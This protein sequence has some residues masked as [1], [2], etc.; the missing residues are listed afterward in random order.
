[1]NDGFE[2]GDLEVYPWAAARVSIWR[3]NHELLAAAVEAAGFDEISPLFYFSQDPD[4]PADVA[5]FLFNLQNYW[6]LQKEIYTSCAVRPTLTNRVSPEGDVT[7][8][9]QLLTHF[10]VSETVRAAEEFADG[11]HVW[12]ANPST[13]W[14]DA[15]TLD[16]NRALFGLDPVES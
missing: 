2:I 5:A 1:V 8:N 11:Y 16:A 10:L 3:Q 13:A 12:H 14:D 6:R 7:G 9:E 4:V 15:L